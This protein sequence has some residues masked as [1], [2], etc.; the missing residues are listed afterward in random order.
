M[1]YSLLIFAAA[2]SAIAGTANA[3]IKIEF[4][5]SLQGF[6]SEFGTVQTDGSGDAVSFTIQNANTGYWRIYSDDPSVDR[7]N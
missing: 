4:R 1:K 3:D 7:L 5:S 6:Y 2:L